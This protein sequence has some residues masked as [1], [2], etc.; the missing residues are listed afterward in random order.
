MAVREGKRSMSWR[1]DKPASL[2]FVEALDG[3]DPAKTVT[4]RDALYTWDATFT[5]QP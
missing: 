5:T 3:G 1:A 2:F 4:H